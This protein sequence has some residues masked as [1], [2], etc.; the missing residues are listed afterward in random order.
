MEQRLSRKS[1][2]P[3]GTH[4]VDIDVSQAVDVLDVVAAQ[5]SDAQSG[6]E[7]GL[8]KVFLFEYQQQIPG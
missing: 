8:D 3:S 2:V 7:I 1:D 4:S 5:S 6:G